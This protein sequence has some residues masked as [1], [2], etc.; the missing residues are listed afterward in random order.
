MTAQEPG[1]AEHTLR[2]TVHTGLRIDAAPRVLRPNRGQFVQF[3]ALMTGAQLVC[4]LC[5][6][7]A[8][9]G[10]VHML[11][12]RLPGAVAAALALSVCAASV[13]AAAIGPPRVLLNRALG[14]F[15]VVLA[16]A[17]NPLH[18]GEQVSAADLATLP[19][20]AFAWRAVV[21]FIAYSMQINLY[22]MLIFG[23][24][25]GIVAVLGNL[26]GHGEVI[27]RVT[28]VPLA[29]LAFGVGFRAAYRGLFGQGLGGYKLVM[30]SAEVPGYT[31]VRAQETMP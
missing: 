28:V 31:P 19:A 30:V 12:A 25:S 17:R 20:R 15:T 22:G 6:F 14:T 1:A 8:A 16:H 21:A 23:L 18:P 27:L 29:A 10:L 26:V 9:F 7:G 13:A 3:V 11:G 5:V 24:S 4:A 2:S